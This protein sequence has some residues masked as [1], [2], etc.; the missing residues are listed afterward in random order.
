MDI[1]DPIQILKL[2][3][4]LIFVVALM[5]GLSI[6]LRKLGLAENYTA[7]KS[8]KRLKIVETLAVDARRRIAIIQCDKDQHLVIIG[9]QG[10]TVIKTDL[11]I[12]EETK[13]NTK[14]DIHENT[15]I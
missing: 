13:D 12:P 9:P 2:L 15:T 1:I 10:E 5:G 14:D 4:A 7:S 11:A 8:E 6:L 3:A